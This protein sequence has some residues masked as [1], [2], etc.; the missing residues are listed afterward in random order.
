MEN[1]ERLYLQNNQIESIEPLSKIVNL[2]YLN[3]RNNLI[4]SIDPLK[5]A[6]RHARILMSD[7]RIEN[8]DAAGNWPCLEEIDVSNNYFLESA[9]SLKQVK[10]NFIH[11]TLSLFEKEIKKS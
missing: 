2:K 9:D 11:I 4:K 6:K 7:K 1:L 10:F 8:I 3:L 5:N